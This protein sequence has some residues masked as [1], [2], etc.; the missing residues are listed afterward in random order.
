M[1]PADVPSVGAALTKWSK[2]REVAWKACAV[3]ASIAGDHGV[4]GAGAVAKASKAIGSAAK[5][6]P[7]DNIVQA[8]A[9]NAMRW[10]AENGESSAR[11]MLLAQ[12]DTVNAA[13]AL[14]PDDK[15]VV[16]HGQE[17]IKILKAHLAKQRT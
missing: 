7:D 16:A 8:N 12:M 14:H 11:M 9:L 15:W 6:H 17:F 13:M 5:H 1:T 10:A 2:N 3:L 4:T